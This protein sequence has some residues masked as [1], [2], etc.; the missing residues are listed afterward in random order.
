MNSCN[1]SFG[2]S[3]SSQRSYFGCAAALAFAGAP[4]YRVSQPCDKGPWELLPGGCIAYPR[5]CGSVYRMTNPA[6]N[7]SKAAPT[8]F[9][10]TESPVAHDV[11]H[12]KV[13]FQ[14]AQERD[15]YWARV[16]NDAKRNIELREFPVAGALEGEMAFAVIDW[17]APLAQPDI[18]KRVM[19]MFGARLAASEFAD[20]AI[21]SGTG[22]RVV[23]EEVRF[24][25]APSDVG[26]YVARGKGDN[27]SGMRSWDWS[28]VR[29]GAVAVDG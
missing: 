8:L 25:L 18:G 2:G 19:K 12:I 29:G 5:P 6:T 10:V 16:P 26:I 1:C 15:G 20:A 9:L 4:A 21:A 11:Q 28:A 24:T 14:T 23:V 22:G 17:D 27:M 3:R 13:A 7:G